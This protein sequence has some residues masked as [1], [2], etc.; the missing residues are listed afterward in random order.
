MKISC[1]VKS[2]HI[3]YGSARGWVPVVDRC[4]YATMAINE[5]Q[6]SQKPWRLKPPFTNIIKV[7]RRRSCVLCGQVTV[8]LPVGRWKMWNDVACS[9]G[10]CAWVKP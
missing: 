1:V 4:P 2:A 8:S 7:N 5:L 6:P 10:V 9:V 3:G